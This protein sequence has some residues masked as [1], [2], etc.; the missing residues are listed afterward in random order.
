MYVTTVTL[1]CYQLKKDGFDEQLSSSSSVW[2]WSRIG[3]ITK[4]YRA[5]TAMIASTILSAELLVIVL[6][7]TRYKN[8]W[9]YR[10]KW[11]KALLIVLIGF[12]FCR[13]T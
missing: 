1:I 5:H 10:I 4:A 7:F 13:C 3:L 9:W 2:S 12:G 8:K 11:I 6:S